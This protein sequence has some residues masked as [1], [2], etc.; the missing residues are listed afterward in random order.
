MNIFEENKLNLELINQIQ[1]VVQSFPDGAER[2]SKI[3]GGSLERMESVK[4]MLALENE[5]GFPFHK[6]SHPTW[7]GV[8]RTYCDHMK[9]G[10]FGKSTGRSISWSDDGS[11]PSEETNEWLLVVKFPTGAFIF[12]DHYPTETFKDFFAELKSFTPKYCDTNN[13]ALYFSSENA[14]QVV[15][16]F[17][18]IKASFSDQSQKERIEKKRIKL[19]EEL[20][21]LK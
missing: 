20:D 18:D 21:S 15:E 16:R 7:I 12:G 13:H 8:G 4:S 11:Q 17:Y 2:Y 14:A 9:V 19:Q 10:Y 3:S 6:D 1:A 5:F